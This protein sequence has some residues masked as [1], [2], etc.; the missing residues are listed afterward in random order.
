MRADEQV[1]SFFPHVVL[2]LMMLLSSLLPR[3]C[4]FIKKKTTEQI[5]A[6]TENSEMRR[7]NCSIYIDVRRTYQEQALH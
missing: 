7:Y 6:V 4:L 5:K 1:I 2:A 3:L